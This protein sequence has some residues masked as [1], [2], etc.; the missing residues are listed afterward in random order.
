MNTLNKENLIPLLGFGPPF[1]VHPTAQSRF[2]QKYKFLC[3]HNFKRDE[4][5]ILPT[6]S[7]RKCVLQEIKLVAHTNTS[8]LDALRI[9]V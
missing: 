1:P 8:F 5:H 4:T 6:A 7:K 2:S 3:P 9:R